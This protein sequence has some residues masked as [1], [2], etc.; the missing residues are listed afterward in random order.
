MKLFIF[1]CLLLFNSSLF[2]QKIEGLFGIKIGEVL[3]KEL[4]D[5]IPDIIGF[6]LKSL[7][8][9]TSMQ[10]LK[11]IKEKVSRISNG[12]RYYIKPRI[13]NKTFKIY[14]VL[15]TPLE[16]KIVTIAANGKVEK[17]SCK[18][19]SKEILKFFEEKYSEYEIQNFMGTT[20][21]LFITKLRKNEINFGWVLHIDCRYISEKNTYL[22]I[23]LTHFP[24]GTELLAL[25]VD[26]LN[27]MIKNIEDKII[28]TKLDTDGF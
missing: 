23:E 17:S 27:N 14:T 4:M 19:L 2:A 16:H 26:S 6:D 9:I 24:R 12:Y 11:M 25:E 15:I 13:P 5:P 8:N 3:T 21:L 1:I 22:T 28:N 10:E 20:K 18:P 7:E